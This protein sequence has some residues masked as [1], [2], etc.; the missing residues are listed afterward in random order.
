MRLTAAIALTAV[1][2]AS[3]GAGAADE[4]ALHRVDLSQRFQ[5]IDHFGASDCWTTKILDTWSEDARTRVADLLFSQ[6][7]GIGL[8]LWRF[9]VGAGRQPDRIKDPL[10]TTESYEMSAGKYDW[11]RMEAERWLLRAAKKRGVSRFHAFS[12]SGTP[13][14]TL[15]GF[16]NADPGPHTV[17][18]KRDAEGDYAR[19]L[20]DVVEH[21]Y[22]GYPVDERVAFDWISPFNE[23]QWE[24]NGGAQEGTRAS[25][26]DVK[27]VAL[28]LDGELRRRS[29]ATRVHLAE[30]GCIPDMSAPN[31][32]MTKKYGVP[33]GGYVDALCGDK[34]LRERLDRTIG[35]HSYWS[36]G[37]DVFGKHRDALRKTLD[38]FPGWRVFQTEYCIMQKGRDLGMD[39]D[40]HVARVM[41]GD[42]SIVNVSGWSWWLALSPHDYKDGLLYTDWKA[43]GDPE[44][45]LQSKMFW[46]IGHHSRFVRPGMVRVAIDGA[47][48]QN[49]VGLLATAYHDAGSGRIV[50]VYV[51]SGTAS[52]SVRLGVAGDARRPKTQRAWITSDAPGDDLRALDATPAGEKLTVPGRALVT[53]VLE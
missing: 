43:K 49:H 10:R 18:L 12:L 24:W 7:K 52:V 2:L 48:L 36:D 13:R 15:N 37:G 9:N 35:Y 33:F 44:T 14:M 51:N 6:E 20:A 27:R 39:S 26:A 19:Y 4:P 30:S 38:A 50:V 53:V 17:N 11:S 25:N 16:V 23:P 42:L 5:T 29:L 22:R 8:S 41:H 34:A 47:P 32:E 45:V 1:L 28:L 40:L 31:A 46:A 21:F 3:P